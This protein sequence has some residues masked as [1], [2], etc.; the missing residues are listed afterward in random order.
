M[1]LYLNSNSIP[2]LDSA[3][4]DMASEHQLKFTRTSENDL[5][6]DRKK[7]EDEK[8]MISIMSHR[9]GDSDKDWAADWRAWRSSAKCIIPIAS[10]TLNWKGKSYKYITGCWEGATVTGDAAPSENKFGKFEMLSALSLLLGVSSCI[11][12]TKAQEW[13]RAE[14]A[15]GNTDW[16]RLGA[17]TKSWEHFWIFL[18]ITF[19]AAA[20]LLFALNT[21]TNEVKRRP[22]M[23]PE[24][25][26]LSIFDQVVELW[27]KI[28]KNG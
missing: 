20:A 22:F 26:K 18:F 17:I 15:K 24:E 9:Q 8:I 2:N 11:K 7:Y 14:I 19:F 3:T 5:E 1:Q 10:V 21:W 27:N 4:S 23:K 28:S 13:Y 25:I 6:G 16:E 12:A